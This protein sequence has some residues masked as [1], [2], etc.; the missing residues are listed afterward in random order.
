MYKIRRNFLVWEVVKE[1]GTLPIYTSFFRYKAVDI[2]N[3]LNGIYL[4]VR[5]GAILERAKE[6]EA[7]LLKAMKALKDM[8]EEF[9][10]LDLP[11]RSRAYSQAINVL[12]KHRFH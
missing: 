12:N 3:C 2:C 8:T 7:N 1:G 11:Y 5:T 9:R 10:M 4:R 6:Q